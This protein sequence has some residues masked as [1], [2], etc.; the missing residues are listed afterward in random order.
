MSCQSPTESENLLH[1]I[2]REQHGGF[3]DILDHPEAYDLQ[4]IYTKIDRDSAQGVHFN[5]F[6]YGMDSSNYF[7]P[8]STVKFPIALLAMEKLNQS[9]M[10]EVHLSTT[11][12]TD[13]NRESQ[14]TVLVD[15][16]S[17]NGFPSIGN[18]VRKVFLVSDNDA[19]NRLYEFVGQEPLNKRLDAL[20]FGNSK[21]T[22]RLSAFLSKE[23]DRYTNPVRF[24]DSAGAVIYSQPEAYSI[25]SFPEGSERHLKGKGYMYGDS[26]VSEPKDFGQSNEMPLAD[27]HEMLQR[28]IFP[29]AF[30]ESQR[31]ALTE[32]DYRF[33][34]KAMGQVPHESVH[35]PYSGDA[36]YDGYCKF[37]LFGDSHEN[38][39]E[40]IRIYNKVGMAY[41]YLIDNAYIIDTKNGVEF[42]LSAVI[43]VNKNG[44]YNDDQYEY[45]AVGFPFLAHLG[46]VLYTYELERKRAV[47]PDFGR[48][49]VIDYKGE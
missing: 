40:H 20:G 14:S 49:T 16:S 18:Y 32:E 33:L 30:D 24:V 10:E 44:I 23:E 1:R 8:A 7:Y 15:R 41:G 37:F 13:S 38:I 43:S 47:R 45:D 42:M 34:Y 21:V 3:S 4:I 46:R 19:S 36:Y 31:F 39:P 12:L 48:F 9:G 26:L 28:V 22:H 25:Y 2:L 35:P 29:E 27:L 6:L 17:A 11:M 5:S